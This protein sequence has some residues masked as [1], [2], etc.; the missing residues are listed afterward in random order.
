MKWLKYSLIRDHLIY[1][2]TGK[3]KRNLTEIGIVRMSTTYYFPV[4]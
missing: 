1:L 4:I 3:L 2:L